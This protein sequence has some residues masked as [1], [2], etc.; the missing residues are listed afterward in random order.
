MSST[1]VPV[2][3]V[4]MILGRGEFPHFLYVVDAVNAWYKPAVH[5]A[6]MYMNHLMQ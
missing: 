1:P 6:L 4:I 2:S 3:K 5:D